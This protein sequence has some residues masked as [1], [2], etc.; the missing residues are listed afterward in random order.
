MKRIKAAAIAKAPSGKTLRRVLYAWFGG[1]FLIGYA[2]GPYS[3][4]HLLP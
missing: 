2:I 4:W 1:T 3:F